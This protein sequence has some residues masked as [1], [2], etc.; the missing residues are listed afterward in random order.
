[1]V[2]PAGAAASAAKLAAELL[3]LGYT[4]WRE[5]NEAKRALGGILLHL[6]VEIERNWKSIQDARNGS[7]HERLRTDVF[8]AC[9]H[10]LIPALRSR[11]SILDPIRM[12]YRQITPGALHRLANRGWDDGVLQEFELLWCALGRASAE[13]DRFLVSEGLLPDDPSNERLYL[14]ALQRVGR[15]HD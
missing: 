5:H 14:Q 9:A 4:S 8:D 1:M 10:A 11:R 6:Q 3:H 2:E 13:V 12:V 7:P 15:G